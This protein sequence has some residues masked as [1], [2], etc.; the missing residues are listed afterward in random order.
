MANC[1][2]AV[3]KDLNTSIN[4]AASQ[5][6]FEYFTTEVKTCLKNVDIDINLIP[7]VD[8]NLWRDIETFDN[9]IN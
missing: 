4:K 6:S 3:R 9:S 5:P 2:K 7:V 8:P 1:L